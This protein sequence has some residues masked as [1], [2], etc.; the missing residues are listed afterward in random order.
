MVE[1]KGITLIALVVTI[2][3]LL[4]LAGISIA[5]LTG[6][7]GIITRTV[8]A[9]AETIKGREREEI[10][11]AY[12]V[13]KTNNYE[14]EN[15]VVDAKDLQ[16]ALNVNGVQNASTSQE[17]NTIKVI[18]TDSTNIYYVDEYGKIH[19]PV[20]REG[21][22]I[23]DYI[24]YT[25]DSAEVYSST[26]LAKDITGVTNNTSDITQ[27]TLNWKVLQ[28]YDDGRMDLVGSTTS[29]DIWFLGPLGYNNGV[30]VINDI[31]ESLYSKS[32]KGITARSINYEDLESWLTENGK[33]NRDKYKSE[34]GVQFGQTKSYTYCRYYLNLYA[35]EKGS[36]INSTT[37]RTDG[38]GISEKS[39][40]EFTVPTKETHTRADETGMTVTQ[41]YW[42]T[43]INTTNFGDGYEALY[44][45]TRY[46]VASRYAN[47]SNP[48]AYFGVRYAGTVSGGIRMYRSDSSYNISN[49]N[50]RIRPVVSLGAYTQVTKSIGTN[51]ESNTHIINW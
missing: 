35:H 1:N 13:A 17:M 38:I 48:V 26:K 7:N 10:A 39:A 28:I 22:K 6:T 3:V 11:L 14:S 16:S 46:W 25:P 24:N 40:P 19:E 9:K 8:E 31:C 18:Y 37:V 33:A 23:G 29:Q 15:S 49:T 30:Y 2:I 51:S 50:C 27:E 32:S 36:G 41:T 42:D 20:S 47:C 43:N 12:S 21:I 45:D 5:M 34:G 44:S 4:I